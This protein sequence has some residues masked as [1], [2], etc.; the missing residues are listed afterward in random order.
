[1]NSPQSNAWQNKH[2]Y[3]RMASL[4]SYPWQEQIHSMYEATRT[5]LAKLHIML[6]ICQKYFIA[7]VEQDWVMLWH[8]K[9]AK[10]CRNRSITT[11]ATKHPTELL[12]NMHES[13]WSIKFTW[14]QNNSRQ[15]LEKSLSQKS[16]ILRGLLC[17][18]VLVTTGIKKIHGVHH[19]KDGMAYNKTH[20]EL[21]PIRCTD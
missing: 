14:Q 17:M 12:Q 5:S 9:I 21:M 10:N 18:L 16:E 6:R 19:W 7:K 13:L 1:M 4:W 3:S 11:I 20:V 8:S 15:G 2:T